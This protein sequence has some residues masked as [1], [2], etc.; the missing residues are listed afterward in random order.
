MWLAQMSAT[1]LKEVLDWTLEEFDFWL[2]VA[3]N[4]Q[5]DFK[6]KPEPDSPPKRENSEI[7]LEDLD[8]LREKQNQK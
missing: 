3:K 4:L 5:N 2:A 7:S 6:G 1:P 8:R